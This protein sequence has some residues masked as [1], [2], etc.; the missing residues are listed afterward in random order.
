MERS[1]ESPAIL[2]F[3]GCYDDFGFDVA[4]DRGYDLASLGFDE[5]FGT[6]FY[7]KMIM[8]RRVAEYVEWI[9]FAGYNAKST[10]VQLLVG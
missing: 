9:R 4:V 3:L 5:G 8:W 7:E 6:C 10:T 1:S 2:D